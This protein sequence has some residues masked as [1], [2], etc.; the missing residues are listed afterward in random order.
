MAGPRRTLTGFLD[1]FAC[2]NSRQ[3]NRPRPVRQRQYVGS[4]VGFRRK[5][6]RAWYKTV[7]VME[8]I[9]D[10][11]RSVP[12]SPQDLLDL[13]T[14]LLLAHGYLVIFLGAVLDN[15]GLPASGDV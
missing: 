7:S 4:I 10:F 8:N 3:H 5:S 11:I 13:V 14:D 15:F 12:D 9:L 1:P 6:R 2:Y